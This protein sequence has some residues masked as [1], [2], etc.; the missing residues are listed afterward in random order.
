MKIQTQPSPVIMNRMPKISPGE[1]RQKR[2]GKV[3]H[4][5]NGVRN[6]CVIQTRQHDKP[7]RSTTYERTGA[8][9]KYK[10][11][12]EM[13]KRRYC[14]HNRVSQY[15]IYFYSFESRVQFRFPTGQIPLPYF[16]D[17][18]LP[19]NSNLYK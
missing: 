10:H 16:G 12:P 15:K 14:C 2:I 4:A 5:E 17:E 3:T 7:E 19:K 13:K 8:F 11:K 9:A 6:I 18:I 1:R